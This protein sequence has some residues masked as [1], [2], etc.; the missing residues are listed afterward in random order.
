MLKTGELYTTKTFLRAFHDAEDN[1][2]LLEEGTVLFIL[3]NEQLED[4]YCIIALY[5]NNIVSIP[6]FIHSKKE[7]ER[8][9]VCLTD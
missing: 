5:E 9:F 4:R 2:R 7:I 3:G 6:F 8:L 1:S